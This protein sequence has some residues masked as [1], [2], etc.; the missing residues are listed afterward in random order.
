MAHD[1]FISY[2]SKDIA[3]AYAVCSTLERAGIRCWIAPRDIPPGH[4]L[5]GHLFEQAITSSIPQSHIFVLV[6]S[7]RAKK[8]TGI[9][10]VQREFEAAWKGEDV[11]LR[12]GDLRGPWL[13]P[14][15]MLS[16]SGSACWLL[17]R[18]SSITAEFTPT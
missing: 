14:T 16:T 9:A 17:F 13:A 4:V 11:E 10:R 15:H 7:T 5:P 6:F 1:V 8:R 3:V 18:V 12:I 2:S